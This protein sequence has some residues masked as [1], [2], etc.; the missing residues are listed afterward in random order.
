MKVRVTPIYGWG[1][2]PIDETRAIDV[3]PEFTFDVIIIESG[4]PF[5][6]AVGLVSKDD[7]PLR[8]MWV[9]LWQRTRGKD[10]T[11]LS[12]RIQ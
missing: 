10:K 4:T 6:T 7:H 9:A 8:G 3:P 2:F 12:L 1:W 11:Y 5:I